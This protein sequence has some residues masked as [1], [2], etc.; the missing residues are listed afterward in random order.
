MYGK[1]IGKQM[2]KLNKLVTLEDCNKLFREI[3]VN[4]PISLTTYGNIKQEE[5]MDEKEFYNL[6]K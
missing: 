5:L 4:T 2:N 3:F 1:L 6:F